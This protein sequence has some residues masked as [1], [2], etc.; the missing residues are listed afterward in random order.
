MKLKPYLNLKIK[1]NYKTKASTIKITLNYI[2]IYYNS[3]LYI[4]M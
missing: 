4:T 2:L 1:A 3:T